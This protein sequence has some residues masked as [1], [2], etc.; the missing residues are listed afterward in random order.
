MPRRW[1][2]CSAHR[3]S[4]FWEHVLIAHFIEPQV[5]LV[6]LSSLHT[7]HMYTF[8]G[9]EPNTNLK[10]STQARKRKTSW[11]LTK[12][13]YTYRTLL[14]NVTGQFGDP[15]NCEPCTQIPYCPPDKVSPSYPYKY[16]Q[17]IRVCLYSFNPLILELTGKDL[18]VVFVVCT[19]NLP[20]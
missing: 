13:T 12:S 7:P 15:N 14:R 20:L 11:A 8:V 9:A 10:N 17:E 2:T 6:H 4:T 5:L 16:T 3:S 19:L 1:S 18:Y